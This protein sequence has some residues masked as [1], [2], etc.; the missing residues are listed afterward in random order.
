MASI[1][2]VG[3]CVLSA[4]VAAAAGCGRGALADAEGSMARKDYSG[5]E[6][7]LDARLAGH[8]DDRPAR[9]DRYLLENLLAAQGAPGEQAAHRSKALDDYAVLVK[10]WGL[11]ENYGDMEASLKASP[12]AAKDYARAHSVLYGN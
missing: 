8:P 1:P 4:L 12:E 5:A 2:W 7:A 6:S 3:V 11:N 9:M 10:A